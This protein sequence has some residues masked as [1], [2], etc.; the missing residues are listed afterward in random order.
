VTPPD[1]RIRNIA[2]G[3]VVRGGRTLV[4][5]YPANDS[6]DTFARAIGGGIEFGETSDTAVRREFEEELGV[7]LTRAEPLAVIESIFTIGGRPGH[8]I[9][10]VFAVESPQ[11]DDLAQGDELAVLDSHTTVR[12]MELDAFRRGDLPYYP[13][14]M[15]DFA[16]AMAGFAEAQDAASPRSSGRQP[17]V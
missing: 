16:E 14:G 10:H 1:D 5:I 9:V 17:S 2:V 12:W 6:H 4:E 3:I 7:T 15:V 8:E 13:V 11:F